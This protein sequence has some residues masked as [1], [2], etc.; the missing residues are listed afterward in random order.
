MEENFDEH[1]KDQNKIKI[2]GIDWIVLLEEALVNM[3]GKQ[4]MKK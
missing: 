1:L 3:M 4:I 2:I